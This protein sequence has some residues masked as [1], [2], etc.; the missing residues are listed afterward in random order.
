[1]KTHLWKIT[2]IKNNCVEEVNLTKEKFLD[3]EKIP[4]N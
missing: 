1:M 2:P 3:G 4:E